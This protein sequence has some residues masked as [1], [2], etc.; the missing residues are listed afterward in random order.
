[1]QRR[2]IF[3]RLVVVLLL[4]AYFVWPT[5]YRRWRKSEENFTFQFRENRFTG[6][7]EVREIIHQRPGSVRMHGDWEELE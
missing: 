1:M 4:L 7:V 5:P 2:A 3:W 6:T